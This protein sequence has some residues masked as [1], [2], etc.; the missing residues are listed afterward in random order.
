MKKLLIVYCISFFI[1]FPSL[2]IAVDNEHKEVNIEKSKE[3]QL[4]AINKR[5]ESL[6]QLKL[7]IES[8]KDKTDIEQCRKNHKDDI[9]EI[10]QERR[11]MKLEQ[12]REQKQKLE[13]KLKKLE[14]QE[15]KMSN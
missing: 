2:V 11:S 10:K 6:S 9:I 1:S 8:A 3:L 13:E 7:C 14:A 12:I 5:I 15:Q 4:K